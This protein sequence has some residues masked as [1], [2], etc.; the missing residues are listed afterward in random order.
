MRVAAKGMGVRLET[1]VRK[2][3]ACVCC[4]GVRSD[5]VVSTSTAIDW[6]LHRLATLAT[7]TQ[8][9]LQTTVGRR[10][11]SASASAGASA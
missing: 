4:D 5:E 3:M 11:T 1:R 7:G 2:R 9:R 8:W 10:R 6:A